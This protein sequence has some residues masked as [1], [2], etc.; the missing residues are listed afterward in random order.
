MRALRVAALLNIGL[1]GAGLGAAFFGLRPGSPVVPLDE[2]MAYLASRPL[3]WSLGWGIW[4]LCALALVAFLAALEREAD[5]SSLASL[6]LLLGTAGMS[7]DLFC[8]V[9]QMVVLPDVAAWKPPQPAAF[10]AWERWLGAGGT[11]VANGLYSIAVVLATLAVRRRVP[12]YAFGLGLATAGS[13]MTMVAAGFS[14][15]A[16]FISATVGPTI[17]SFVLWCA[18]TSWTIERRAPP[19]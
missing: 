15:R 12:G 13:G 19:A 9:G 3:A 10:V 4:M 17:V 7:V 11:V 2:R 1:H 18:A 16:P 14:G 8:N 5:G 6:G